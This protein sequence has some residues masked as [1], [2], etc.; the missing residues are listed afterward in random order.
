LPVAGRLLLIFKYRT[1][2]CN[3]KLWALELV[4]RL[5]IPETHQK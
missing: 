2:A 3:S 5:L 1:K 4:L